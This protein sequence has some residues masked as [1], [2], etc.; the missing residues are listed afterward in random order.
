MSLAIFPAGQLVS[1]LVYKD[2]VPPAPELTSS[3]VRPTEELTN[4]DAP[5]RVDATCDAAL[6]TVPEMCEESAGKFERMRAPDSIHLSAQEFAQI[7]DEFGTGEVANTR[8]VA[9]D[10]ACADAPTAFF[11]SHV[12]AHSTLWVND[13]E[14]SASKVDSYLTSIP[15][16]KTKLETAGYQ[17]VALSTRMSLNEPFN[18]MV[19]SFALI[20]FSSTVSVSVESYI[21]SVRSSGETES[22]QIES[23]SDRK[24]SKS[25]TGIILA[26]MRLEPL[27]ERDSSGNRFFKV[28]AT[29]WKKPVKPP[30]STA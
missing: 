29:V 21:E 20:N 30:M 5:D 14:A 9:A 25:D 16:D 13:K 18:P 10:L 1:R 15:L 26:D 22:G 2:A 23:G 19:I 24:F 28:T 8:E 7:T 27:N 12:S 3:T 11:S 6:A 17:P 4:L